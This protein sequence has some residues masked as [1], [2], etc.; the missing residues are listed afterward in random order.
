MIFLALK[1]LFTRPQQTFLTFLA[2]VIGSIGYILFT[3]IM[4]G[5]QEYIIEQLVN[6]DAQIRISPRDE[7]ITEGNHWE[8][9]N[10]Y[11]IYV[12][13]RQRGTYYDQ[14]IGIRRLNS[15]KP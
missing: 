3:S 15:R 7:T 5:F 4:F 8:T 10:D 1:Q 2:I 9:E 14:L 12:Y 6:S 13:H 11:S